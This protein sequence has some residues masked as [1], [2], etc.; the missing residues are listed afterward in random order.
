MHLQH[1]KDKVL[2][3]AVVLAQE[4]VSNVVNLLLDA[5]ADALDTAIGV[6]T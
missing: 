3:V 4:A 5:V 6:G 1:A 2:V